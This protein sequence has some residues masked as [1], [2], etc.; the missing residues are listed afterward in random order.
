VGSR[1][2]RSLDIVPNIPSGYSVLRER[3]N[4]QNAPKFLPWDTIKMI[5]IGR[6]FPG[7]VVET[8]PVIAG[9]GVVDRGTMNK[10]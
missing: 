1:R 7:S 4:K 6:W 10:G 2:K 9:S 8:S 5:I 3:K